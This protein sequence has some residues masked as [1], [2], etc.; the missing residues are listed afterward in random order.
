MRSTMGLRGLMLAAAVLA[1][2]AAKAEVFWTVP[3]GSTPLFTYQNGYENNGL[4]GDPV[5]VGNTFVFTPPAFSAV[6]PV[7]NAATDT[8]QVTI[9][10]QPGQTITSIVIRE[11]G[12]RTSTNL[13]TV[14]ATSFITNLTNTTGPVPGSLVFDSNLNWSG[15][16]TRVLNYD[17]STPFQLALTDNISALIAGQSIIKT[18]VEI[19]IMPTPS[20]A[21]VLAGAGLAAAV[22]RRRR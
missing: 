7:R 1:P 15:S 8:L 13:T 6:N 2:A 9:R 14:Q 20:G 5:I 19:E 4:F 21:V 3:N 12:T 10:A 17:S 11:F 22:R 16:V 18:R